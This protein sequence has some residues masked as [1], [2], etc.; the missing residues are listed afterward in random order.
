MISR[1][2]MAS[3]SKSKGLSFHDFLNGLREFELQFKSTSA[4]SS[5]SRRFNNL[6][7]GLECEFEIITED[8]ESLRK[9]RD[10]LI[11]K[12]SYFVFLSWN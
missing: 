3:S 7:D 2:S 6:L 1:L 9:E 10:E 11:E 4:I 5:R 8:I 12:G